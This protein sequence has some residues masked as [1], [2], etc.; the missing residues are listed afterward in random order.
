MRETGLSV[1]QLAEAVGG[2]IAYS[3]GQ[4]PLQGVR[5]SDVT[6]DSRIVVQ[7]ALFC[8]VVGHEHDGHDF[9]ADA[10]AAGAQALLVERILDLGVPQVAVPSVRA[11]LGPAAAALWDYPWQRCK[12]IGVTGTAGKTTVTHSIAAI[13]R[14][15]GST[16]EVVGTLD[17]P[18]TT[19]EAPDLFRRLDSAARSGADLAVLEVSSHALELGR[20]DG[21]RFA[22]GV[23]TNLSHEHMDFHG[24]MED[25]F[26]AKARL[27]D[28]RSTAAVIN[29]DDAW[30]RRMV[31]FAAKATPHVHPW[32]PDDITV[33]ATRGLE[34]SWKGRRIS[35]GLLG[36][37]N[38]A[39]VA[40]AAAAT[41]AVGFDPDDV[42]SGISSIEPVRGRLW[43]VSTSNDDITVLVDFAHKPDA[44]AAVLASAR[45]LGSPHGRVWAVFG[46][47]GDRDRSKRFLMGE[48]ADCHADVLVVTSDNPRS[49]DPADI[50]AA[51]AAG[52][53]HRRG[54]A[55]GLHIELDRARAIALA[56][57]NAQA[58]DVV[59]VAGK[60]H[61]TVQI[62]S[63]GSV[64]FD[65][66]VVSGE[67][68]E[69]RREQRRHTRHR[70]AAR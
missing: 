24:T 59:V 19:P 54:D 50:A 51:V 21:A 6:H 31:D 18:R 58:G 61:E 45:E 10:I 13:A 36:R 63:S 32:R 64:A 15:C 70:K 34:G 41:L 52:A 60:G 27:F 9:A 29:V 28:G 46:A 39:N 3:H 16:C 44:L 22:A 67:L 12:L 66:A 62:R 69:R 23:F 53:P 47:G 1:E 57:E 17:G 65:D 56:I 8:C 42:A 33:T 49:E 35:C 11:A 40:A 48:A 20:V 68:L 4:R 14:S 26:S 38:A 5:V 55:H 25:Y 43:P 37:L 7:G 2:T 30:G